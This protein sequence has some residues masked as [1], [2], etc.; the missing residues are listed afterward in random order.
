MAICS[1]TW[2][3]PLQAWIKSKLSTTTVSSNDAVSLMLIIWRLFFVL[4]FASCR[5][6]MCAS[7]CFHLL[8]NMTKMSESSATTVA[9]DASFAIFRAVLTIVK[10]AFPG[11][12]V[13]CWPCSW[14]TRFGMNRIKTCSFTTIVYFANSKKQTLKESSYRSR[15]WIF[16]WENNRIRIEIQ[17]NLDFSNTELFGFPNFSNYFL[18]PLDT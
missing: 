5:T 18:D 13:N 2:S 17:F 14:S 1:R 9:C 16:S 6:D 12:I 10:S 8:N 3:H 4:L 7:S 15:Y 11:Q